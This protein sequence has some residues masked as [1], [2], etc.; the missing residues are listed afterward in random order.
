MIIIL[1]LRWNASVLSSQE[2]TGRIEAIYI[3]LCEEFPVARKAT[4]AGQRRY[5]SRWKLTVSAYYANRIRVLNSEA[6]FDSMKGTNLALHNINDATLVCLYSALN[7][8][9]C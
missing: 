8:Y 5:T 4:A 6:V 2:P 7:E 3:L 9:E 1:P